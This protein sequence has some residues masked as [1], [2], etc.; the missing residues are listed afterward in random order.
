MSQTIQPLAFQPDMEHPEEQEAETT[1]GLDK[2]L[3]GIRE[4]TLADTGQ[5]L[6][7][8]HAKS[9]GILNATLTIADNLAPPYA[10]GLF[11]RPGSYDAILRFSTI[12]GDL[13]SDDVSVPR[14]LALKVL[15]VEGPRL[16]GSEGETTQD[17][18]MV[19][20]PAF[21]APTA[22]KFLG[23]L[24][25][26]AGTTDKYEGLKETVSHVARA[27]EALLEAFGKKS[28]LVTALG[29]HP[30]T[31]ILGEVFYS[32]TPFLFGPYYAK[33]AIRPVSPNLTALAGQKLD[34]RHHP[35][36]IREAVI[37]HF[38]AEG[39][40]WA[41]QVQLAT[42]RDAMPVEDA[43]VV[44]PEDKSPYVT[45]AHIAAPAQ[46][47]WTGDKQR[48][49]DTGLSFSPWHGLADHR[50]LGGVN[51]T[52]RDTYRASAEFRS[53]R[54]CPVAPKTQGTSLG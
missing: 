41:L 9:H 50:P 27:A 31:N 2:T 18:L 54:A 20:A 43:S 8:V 10:Q 21:A 42:D 3:T 17:F 15:A 24:K 22:R 44:W 45:I 4:K 1:A 7:S 11:A 5:A 6:R 14:G 32:Q 51:R 52:R 39:G 47:A 48:D 38:A 16:P 23:N 35:N 29:G 33:F 36:A 19:D 37:S 34:V 46:D 26:L 25:T 12:P 53:A 30:A 28:G 13:L 49:L 40:E